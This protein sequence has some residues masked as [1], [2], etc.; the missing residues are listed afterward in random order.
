MQQ[1]SLLTALGTTLLMQSVASSKGQCLPVVAPLLTAQAG[2]GTQAIGVTSALTSAGTVLFP[3][4][5]GPLLVRMGSVQVPQAESL[6]GAAS[7]AIRAIDWWPA[8]LVAPLFLGVGY[9]P[10]PPPAQPLQVKGSKSLPLRRRGA[11]PLA[12]S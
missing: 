1:V 12:G 9:G 2:V 7:L 3:A 11:V 4:F 5:G 6:L 10:T 8:L